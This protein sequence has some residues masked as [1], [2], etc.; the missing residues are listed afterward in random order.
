VLVIEHLRAADAH[1]TVNQWM[2]SP[3]IQSLIHPSD[4][5]DEFIEMTRL[6]ARAMSDF[7]LRS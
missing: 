1:R 5:V 6:D 2:L 4:R 3:E 7:R